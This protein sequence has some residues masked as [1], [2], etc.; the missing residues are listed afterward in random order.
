MLVS[1]ERNFVIEKKLKGKH[2]G[3]VVD[4]VDEEQL[5]RIRVKI[6]G[7]MECDDSDI[8]FL[9]LISP[10]TSIG[11]SQ[12]NNS[13]KIPQINSMVKVEFLDDNI[14]SGFY[15]HSVVSKKSFPE[16]FTKD[17]PNSEG[18]T[19]AGEGELPSW[20]RINK[21]EK[22]CEIFL[23]PSKTLLKI[24]IEGS[25]YLNTEKDVSIIS[26]TSI[27]MSAKNNINL[28]ASNVN[29]K[30]TT[31]NVDATSQNI[32]STNLFI[33]SINSSLDLGAL[34]KKT[35]SESYSTNSFG[36]TVPNFVVN[37]IIKAATA[38]FGILN[39]SPLETLYTGPITY[40]GT[41]F[42]PTPVDP[43]TLTPPDLTSVQTAEGILSYIKD[44]TNS[45]I[46]DYTNTS[47]FMSLRSNEIRLQFMKMA[48]KMIGS[49]N[50]KVPTEETN[51]LEP[52]RLAEELTVAKT[53]V[54]ELEKV[55]IDLIENQADA[56]VSLA[57]LQAKHLSDVTTAQPDLASG[58]T[59]Q[60]DYK[61]IIGGMDF[62]VQTEVL[63]KHNSTAPDPLK[64]TPPGGYSDF[65]STPPDV[66]S[67]WF[68]T[69][70]KEDFLPVV[71]GTIFNLSNF[72]GLSIWGQTNAL[73]TTTNDKIEN[74]VPGFTQPQKDQ[75]NLFVEKV[76]RIEIISCKVYELIKLIEDLVKALSNLQLD[77]NK[78]LASITSIEVILP[79]W[80]IDFVNQLINGIKTG[81]LPKFCQVGSV[82]Q[83]ELQTLPDDLALLLGKENQIVLS[84]YQNEKL[85]S[86]LVSSV[87][88]ATDFL[89][90]AT[91]W[92]K[93]STPSSGVT[94]TGIN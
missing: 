24:D 57:S 70:P 45:F 38:S 31:F 34:V 62:E 49:K 55:K 64:L 17:Y 52:Y 3:I 72:L 88:P 15:L 94:I 90:A 8:K 9:P 39:G 51:Y 56:N 63:D 75:F 29:I 10:A 53:A 5:G 6:A 1:L 84:A 40:N 66:Y 86:T 50:Y 25:V 80:I 43:G 76:R 12:D 19:W 59:S 69:V 36:V 60:N 92:T 81:D 11:G 91:N 82:S 68:G 73:T 23:M 28:F 30:S 18:S 33:K 93:S 48:S 74:V 35:V 77:L 58:Y 71:N 85:Y 67:Q 46:L 54:N 78:I 21:K 87:L 20:F 41:P 61:Q 37:G 16:V 7:V 65:R 79:T 22:Y 47:E 32:N 26:N 89:T 42:V 27:N 83:E 44:L 13:I 14:D 4:N 2:F